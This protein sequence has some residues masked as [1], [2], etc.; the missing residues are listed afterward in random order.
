MIGKVQVL[1][2]FIDVK[3]LKN[4]MRRVPFQGRLSVAGDLAVFLEEKLGS[5]LE[6]KVLK[7]PRLSLSL[8]SKVP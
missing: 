7:G 5:A 4:S 6:Q 8:F 3:A 2:L 1:R